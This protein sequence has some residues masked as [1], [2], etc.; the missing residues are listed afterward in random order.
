MNS[1]SQQ[2]NFPALID[3]EFGQ[4][5]KT[6]VPAPLGGPPLPGTVRELCKKKKLS[7]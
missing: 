2:Q 4:E 1:N 3:Q 6:M 5:F 7:S